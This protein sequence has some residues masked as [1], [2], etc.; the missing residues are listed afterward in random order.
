MKIE[1]KLIRDGGMIGDTVWVCDF[2]QPDLNKK[3]IRHVKPTK[4]LVKSNDDLPK[5][6]TVYYSDNH[7]S[8]I[9]SKGK[10]TSK[11][12]SPVDN[13]GFRM[14]SGVE[15]AVFDDETQCKQHYKS[16]CQNII[17]RYQVI[18]GTALDGLKGRQMEI[19]NHKNSI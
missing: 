3:A 12:I 18:I 17:D 15:L 13:T 8:P 14:R 1:T 16:Q 5:N 11:I 4:V 6:K 2:R 7:F 10:V 19:I 9:N